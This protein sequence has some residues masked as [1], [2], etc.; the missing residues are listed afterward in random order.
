MIL[1]PD[2]HS[3]LTLELYG[4]SNVQLLLEVQFC[5]NYCHHGY[6]FS[7]LIINA[8][9]HTSR[10]TVNIHTRDVTVIILSVWNT[11]FYCV[12]VTKTTSP[13]PHLHP[14]KGLDITFFFVSSSFPWAPKDSVEY[15]ILQWV[16][17]L[18]R[19]ER[20]THYTTW[21][22][23]TPLSSVCILIIQGLLFSVILLLYKLVLFS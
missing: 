21:P 10:H 16:A 1:Y 5:N 4:L 11:F 18:G 23:Y 2:L 3:W 9:R 22:N 19:G 12:V 8:N 13:N 20:C 7:H 6:Y 15:T 17:T 14:N